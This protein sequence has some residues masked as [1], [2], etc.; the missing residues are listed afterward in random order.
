MIRH[1]WDRM[2]SNVMRDLLKVKFSDEELAVLLLN[3]GTHTLVEGNNWHD[4][5]WGSCR[6]NRLSCREPGGNMLGQ[7]LMGIR[8]LIR[9]GHSLLEQGQ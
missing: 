4:Q 2:K 1:D 7:H 3:T 9:N 6:C 8:A 5:Y